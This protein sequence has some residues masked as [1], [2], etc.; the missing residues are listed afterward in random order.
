[1]TTPCTFNDLSDAQQTLELRNYFESLKLEKLPQNEFDSEHWPKELVNLL[2]SLNCC[3]QKTEVSNQDLADLLLTFATMILMIPR[4]DENWSK[5]TSMFCDLF[6]SNLNTHPERVNTAIFSLDVLFKALEGNHD[7]YMVYMTLLDCARK[8]KLVNQLMT[9][10]ELT[11]QWLAKSNCTQ[12]ECRKLWRKLHEV[13]LE[14]DDNKKAF[15]F[16]IQLLNTYGD[17]DAAKARDDA[18]K[19]ILIAIKDPNIVIYDQLLNLSPIQFIEGEPLHDLLQ[20]FVSGDLKGFEAF[21]KKNK[22]L[23]TENELNEQALQDKIRVL[24]FMQMSE[25]KSE[26]SYDSVK[27]ALNLEDDA[28]FRDFIINVVRHKCV[29]CKL[30]EQNRKVLIVTSLP[31]SFGP[32][33]WKNLLSGLLQWKSGIEHV[34]QSLLKMLG[35]RVAH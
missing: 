30:D 12:E 24:S 29:V 1:M 10:I 25:N 31:R 32:E 34:N 23:I 6:S 5:A 14:L 16:L 2:P 35:P 19:C 3:F 4:T 26:L 28:Q 27:T 18:I 15:N 9:D 22:K 21:V 33:Q 7:R 17:T 8:L 11:D 20:L 13:H